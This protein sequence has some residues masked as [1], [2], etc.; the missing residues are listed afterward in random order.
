MNEPFI[1]YVSINEAVAQTRRGCL[2]MLTINTHSYSSGKSE[3][4]T[5]LP[6]PDKVLTEKGDNIYSSKQHYKM[7]LTAAHYHEDK[8]TYLRAKETR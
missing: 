4:H 8:H 3:I 5:A 1:G 6:F 7:V 2:K